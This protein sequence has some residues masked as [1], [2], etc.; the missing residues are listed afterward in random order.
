[1]KINPFFPVFIAIVGVVIYAQ[2]NAEKKPESST[3][4]TPKEYIEMVEKTKEERIRKSRE[5]AEKEKSAA[6]ESAAAPVKPSN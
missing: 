6:E 5:E 2:Y 4:V 3:T 1:M